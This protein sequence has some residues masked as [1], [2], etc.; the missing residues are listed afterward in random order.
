MS[1]Y[2]SARGARPSK[3]S[4]SLATVVALA[5]L[6]FAASVAKPGSPSRTISVPVYILGATGK[7][8]PVAEIPK[9]LVIELGVIAGSVGGTPDVEV[10]TIRVGP[11]GDI[12]LDLADLSAKLDQHAVRFSER[13]GTRLELAPIAARF[14]RVSTGAS[15]GS[16]SL[17]GMAVVFWDIEANGSLVPLFCDRPCTLRVPDSAE[18]FDFNVPSPGVGWML[19]TKNQKSRFV[20]V[21]AINPNPVI[22][23]A[24]P[25]AFEKISPSTFAK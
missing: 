11:E 19:S 12:R 1:S 17:A 9:D 5:T 4:T 13:S 3:M 6:G 24:P 10:Q 20:H 18:E 23:I 21:R 8:S 22:V 25:D 2:S 7:P 15:K 16:V 14:A